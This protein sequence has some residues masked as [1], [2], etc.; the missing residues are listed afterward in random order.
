M[1]RYREDTPA[2]RDWTDAIISAMP[3][4]EQVTGTPVAADGKMEILA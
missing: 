3:T 1:Q 4:Y 2:A